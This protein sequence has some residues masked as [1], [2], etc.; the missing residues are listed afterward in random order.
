[1]RHWVSNSME[2]TATPTSF[3]PAARRSGFGFSLIE[4]VV[5]VAILAVISVVAVNTLLL[6]HRALAEIRTTR[7]LDATAAVA[8]ERMIRTIRDAKSVTSIVGT[9]L[10]LAGS[11]AAPVTYTFDVDAN[12]LRIDSGSGPVILTPPGVTVSG[13]AFQKSDLA[14]GGKSE[15]VKVVLT[16]QAS[17]GQ[18]VKTQSF[19]GTAVLRNSYGQ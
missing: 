16:L 7:S 5:Y 10:V 14:T 3:P 13:L 1:M 9:T 2:E 15:A 4:V 19:Y 12:T 18:T 11:E 8:M 6:I 17:S